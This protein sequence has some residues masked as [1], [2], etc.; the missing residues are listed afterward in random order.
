MNGLFD[1][2]VADPNAYDLEA[3]IE[4]TRGCPYACTYCEIGTK[5]YNK[6][7]THKLEKIYVEIDWLADNKV[8][9]V[10]NADSNF[11]MLKDH[12]PITEYLVK[13]KKETG[14]PD[15]HRCDWSKNQADKVIKLA[16]IFYDAEMDKG[17]TIATIMNPTRK[18][19]KEKMLTM[20][21]WLNF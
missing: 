15:K 8:V 14:Y 3:T 7:K 6:I 16:K 21:S 9:F 20:V 17:I 4:T 13:K 2:L 12:L 1:K 19:V 11:G 18:A 5:Y 10:Y